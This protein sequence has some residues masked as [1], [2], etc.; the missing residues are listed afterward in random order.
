MPDLGPLGHSRPAHRAH[1]WCSHCPGRTVEEE[2]AAWQV[3]ED[4]RTAVSDMTDRM[5]DLEQQVID[6]GGHQHA[7]EEYSAAIARVHAYLISLCDEPHPSHDHL[8]PDDVRRDI[9]TA[10]DQPQA[11]EE[12]R[13]GLKAKVDE[14]T[15]TLRRVRALHARTTVQTTGGPADACSSCETDGMSYPWPCPTTEAL[16]GPRPDD[17][18]PTV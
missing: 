11:A 8:C 1:G 6:L 4:A 18:T 3:R 15:S 16:A 13:D 5:A 2:L 9:L 10:L 17:H 7:A 14:A 12:Q